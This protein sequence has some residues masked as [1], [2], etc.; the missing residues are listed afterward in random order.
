VSRILCKRPISIPDPDV[1]TDLVGSSA[2]A[3]RPN[4]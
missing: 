2:R 3:L 4:V 1:M